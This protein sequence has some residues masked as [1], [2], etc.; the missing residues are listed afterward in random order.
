MKKTF[1][2]LA[3]GAFDLPVSK[4]TSSHHFAVL[5]DA[6][7]LEQRHAGTRRLNRLR[8]DEFDRRFPG[9]IALVVDHA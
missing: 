6:G 4:A 2:T 7:L 9:L 3:C 1:W 8:R 5:R